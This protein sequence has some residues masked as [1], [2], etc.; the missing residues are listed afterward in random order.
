MSGAMAGEPAQLPADGG[1]TAGEP[2]ALPADGGVKKEEKIV[3]AIGGI[4]K[5]KKIAPWQRSVGND[6]V[7]VSDDDSHTEEEEHP[8]EEHPPIIAR[9]IAAVGPLTVTLPQNIGKDVEPDHIVNKSIT[10]KKRSVHQRSIH[11]SLHGG[12]QLLAQSHSQTVIL[13]QNIGRDVV[14]HHAED[15]G[16][17]KL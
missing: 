5:E 1:A 16:E 12:L 11:Q 10:R 14:H 8:P 4:K 3:P 15:A 17:A 13:P 7:N 6:I 9:R 2:A